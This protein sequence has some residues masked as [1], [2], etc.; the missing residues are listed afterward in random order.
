M[1]MPEV[2]GDQVED[3]GALVSAEAAGGLAPLVL[4]DEVVAD[5]AGQLV[6]RPGPGS[7]DG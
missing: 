5:L 3:H 1:S 7:R 2:R 6:A 4:P